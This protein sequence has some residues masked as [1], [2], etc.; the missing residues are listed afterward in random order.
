MGRKKKPKPDDPEQS[1]RFLE[2]AKRIKADNDKE[3][4]ENA[5]RKIVK[6]KP[7]KTR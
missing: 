7:P 5:V 2:T 4:F 3:L 1:A 6:V